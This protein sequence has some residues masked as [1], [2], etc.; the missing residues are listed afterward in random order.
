MMMR[1]VFLVA[2][3]V[4]AAAT[5]AFAK[6]DPPPAV[7]VVVPPAAQEVIDTL[8]EAVAAQLAD[9]PVRLEVDRVEEFP[10]VLPQQVEVARAAAIRND[11]VLVFWLDASLA[12]QMFLYLSEPGGGRILV[13]T[14]ESGGDAE[15]VEA[16]ALIVRGTIEA[17]LA[18]GRLGV[19]TPTPPPPPPPPSPPPPPPPAPDLLGVR[20]AYALEFFSTDALAIHGLDLGILVHVYSGLSLFAGY[21][22]VTDAETSSRGVALDVARNPMELGVQYAYQLGDWA[23]GGSVSA[24]LDRLHG[25]ATTTTATLVVRPPET[26]WLAGVGAAFHTSFRI[27]GTVHAFIDAGVD[28]YVDTVDYVVETTGGRWTMLTTWVARPRLL[29]G[30]AADLF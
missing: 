15:R 1:H 12:D 14:V 3:L 24:L 19:E 5:S 22:V 6:A 9:M 28:V 11:A 16:V 17:M 21:R 25:E 30:L 18:G 23:F 20:L 13:R 29:L 10:A 26:R 7:V 4:T 2:L 27:A 8:L